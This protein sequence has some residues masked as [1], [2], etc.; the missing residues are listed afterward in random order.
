MKTKLELPKCPVCGSIAPDDMP[1]NEE[2]CT[3]SISTMYDSY[4]VWHEKCGKD[5]HYFCFPLR[6]TKR[7]AINAAN[8][9]LKKM[10]GEE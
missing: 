9:L 8:R 7:G 10:G 5:Y 2:G 4:M 6:K 3:W 1:I